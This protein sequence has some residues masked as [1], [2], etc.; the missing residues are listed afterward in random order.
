MTI[1][2]LLGHKL[3]IKKRKIDTLV[4]I[5]R[6]YYDYCELSALLSIENKLLAIKIGDN[7][8]IMYSHPSKLGQDVFTL[9]HIHV[10]NG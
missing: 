5:F 4:F 1:H 2:N 7:N 9:Y 6:M 3:H 8:K 10:K